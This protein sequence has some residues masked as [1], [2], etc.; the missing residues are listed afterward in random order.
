MK[1]FGLR[2]SDREMYHAAA[3]MASNFLVT[4][5]GA[6]EQLMA[7][8]GV[9]RDLLV[10]LVRAAVE[11][12]ARLGPRRA[13][14]GPIARGDLATAARQRNALAERAPE[15]LPLWDALSDATKAL[16]RE[17]PA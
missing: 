7:Q 11:N 6:A 12:W 17:K 8:V 10:P 3:S 4:L 14:T 1:P 9:E 15:L 2:D 13:L 5:E 16:A